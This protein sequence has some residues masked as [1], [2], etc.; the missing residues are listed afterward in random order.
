MMNFYKFSRWRFGVLVILA[1]L[2]GCKHPVQ[3]VQAE[4]YTPT[5][6]A[7]GLDIIRLGATEGEQR[8]LATYSDG[9][10]NTRFDIELEPASAS[11]NAG[12]PDMGKGRF[13]S[14]TDSDPLPLL[15]TLKGALQANRVPNHAQKVDALPFG[16]L[17]VGENQSR[18]PA[19]SF[20]PSPPGNWLVIKIFLANDQA[21]VYFDL[22]PVIHKAEFAMKD[23]AYGDRVLSEL[24]KVF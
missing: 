24:A 15:H 11:A 16:Y 5:G 2:V 12:A 20:R 21:E 18:T 17:L 22:N 1:S 9:V 10:H 3:E 4:Q 8:W 13:V 7:V 19:G 14:E 23:P 6:S